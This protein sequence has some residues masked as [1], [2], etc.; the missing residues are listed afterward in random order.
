MA[1][2]LFLLSLPAPARGHHVV[3]E[4]IGELAGALSH[5]HVKL[6]L[7]LSSIHLNLQQYN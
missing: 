6:T 3:F 5:I 2:S 4:Q 1:L 7:N